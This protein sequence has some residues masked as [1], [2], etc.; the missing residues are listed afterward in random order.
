LAIGLINEM[1][2]PDHVYDAAVA[3]AARFTDSSPEVLAAAKAA[4]SQAR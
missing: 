4:F 3:W 1:A 2:A